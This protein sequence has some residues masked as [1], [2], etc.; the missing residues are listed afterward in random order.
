MDYSGVDVPFLPKNF[1]KDE[2]EKFRSKFWIGKVPV[3]IEKIIE[4]KLNLDIIPLPGLMK[5]CDTDAFIASGWEAIYVDNDR[6]LDDRYQNRLRFSLAHEIGHLV[7]HQEIYKSFKI[8]NMESFY[9]FIDQIPTSTYNKLE[10]QA[11]CFAGYLLVPREVLFAE[12]E[13]I[14]KQAIK[15]NPELKEISDDTL[16]DYLAA[17][18][19]DIFNVSAEA[20]TTSLSNP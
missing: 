1:I 10:F 5:Q 17:Q 20:I 7:L 13:K 8:A 4:Q 2:A 14:K 11:N 6:Y 15:N 16:R 18:L 3:N 9:K 19:V 12:Y